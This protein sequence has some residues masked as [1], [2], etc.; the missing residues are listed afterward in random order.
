[1]YT[2]RFKRQVVSEVLSGQ[3]T[4]RGASRK[5]GIGGNTTVHKWCIKYGGDY[6]LEGLY[7][8]LPSSF[9]SKS[10][11]MRKKKSS[12]SL[13]DDPKILKQRIAQLETQLEAESL[14][15]EAFEKV[16]EIAKRDLKIDLT[17]KFDTKQSP[18]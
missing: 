1:M 6:Y 2:E 5:Y 15:R 3:L 9:H 10:K 12:V 16:I 7:I 4:R 11:T 13:P 18:K 17:K 8:D 14:K